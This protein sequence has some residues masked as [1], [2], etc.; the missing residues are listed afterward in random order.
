MAPFVGELFGKGRSPSLLLIG[1]SHYLE[2]DC[3]LRS[4]E[5]WYSGEMKDLTQEQIDYIDT[6]RLLA[7]SVAVGFTAKSH[8]IFRNS[9]H[10]INQNGPKYSDARS[11]SK[12]IAFYNFFLRPAVDGGSIADDIAPVDY[13][14]ANNAFRVQFERLNPTAIVFLSRFAYHSCSWFPAVP[15]VATPHPGCRWWNRAAASYGNRK[16]R[17]L[18]ADFV[19]A[20]DWMD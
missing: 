5:S 3:S 2:D 15:I 16:G 12:K 10:Q 7:D 6:H 19:S 14:Y 9:F 11:V 8:S 13:E 18:L 1:E 4:P 17:E 20:M